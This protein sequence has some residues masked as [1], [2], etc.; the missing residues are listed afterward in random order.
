MT[1][2]EWIQSVAFPF[3]I[4]GVLLIDLGPSATSNVFQTANN[5]A[6]ICRYWK[7]QSSEQELH[8]SLHAVEAESWGAQASAGISNIAL[9][10]TLYDH[11]LDTV[12]WLG[13]IPKRFQVRVWLLVP[14]G[15]V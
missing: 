2:N 15:Y 5:P 10:A 4:V 6:L 11:V 13:A 1:A 9:D 8:A 12:Y 7:G 3:L 14:L